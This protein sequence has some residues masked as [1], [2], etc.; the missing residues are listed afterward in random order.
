MVTLDGFERY[1]TGSALAR[2]REVTI[3]LEKKA[4][5]LEMFGR[6]GVRLMEKVDKD[7][8]QFPLRVQLGGNTGGGGGGA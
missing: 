8:S 3:G 5:I 4:G 6:H 2:I 1:K 7:E